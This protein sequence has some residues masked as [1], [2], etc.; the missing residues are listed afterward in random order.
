MNTFNENQT[1]TIDFE[2]SPKLERLLKVAN[3]PLGM[4]KE[5]K[6]IGFS[7]AKNFFKTTVIFI[8]L[9]LFFLIVATYFLFTKDFASSKIF[10][11]FLVFVFGF[12]FIFYSIYKLYNLVRLE[13]SGYVFEQFSPLVKKISEGIIA[14]SEEK[15]NGFVDIRETQQIIG[16]YTSKVPRIF[17]TILI[18]ILGRIPA[19]GFLVDIY[20]NNSLRTT[21][22]RSLFLN[23]KINSFVNNSIEERKNSKWLV[24]T[25]IINVAIQ[26][27]LIYLIY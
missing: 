19:T 15:I 8:F 11:T 4:I 16:N 21:E 17:K 13:F 20:N 23:D 9:N 12:I 18:F 10:F 2:I 27:G 25:I 5:M 3:K 24:W 7:S 6:N 26:L 1:E 22:D 14:K